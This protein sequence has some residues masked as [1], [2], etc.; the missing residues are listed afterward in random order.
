MGEKMIPSIETFYKG[1]KTRSR[2]EARWLYF[3]D[4]IG[5]KYEYEID[6]FKD[7]KTGLYYLPDVYLPTFDCYVEIKSAHV[8]DTPEGDEAER[9]LSKFF[10]D[11][12]ESIGL[13][14][15]GDP[16]EYE[17]RCFCVTCS[18][19][20]DCVGTDKLNASFELSPYGLGVVLVCRPL[21]PEED[22]PS[23][24]GCCGSDLVQNE[25]DFIEC[26]IVQTLSVLH[27]VDIFKDFKL[28]VHAAGEKARQARYE[29]G[30]NPE[31]TVDT[32]YAIFLN[33]YET[34]CFEH[35]YSLLENFASAIYFHTKISPINADADADNGHA[36]SNMYKDKKH[37]LDRLTILYKRLIEE[38]YSHY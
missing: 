12:G 2:L 1:Y 21:W 36:L 9:K 31:K 19:D 16:Y 5:L 8:K 28:M 30:E 26:E 3:F 25:D 13:I 20:G 23:I 15:Y 33:S 6:G 37:K 4:L 18:Q 38:H 7:D 29:Y 34:R 24:W 35:M 10:G 27:D 22:P 11:I 14:I 32:D 17:T